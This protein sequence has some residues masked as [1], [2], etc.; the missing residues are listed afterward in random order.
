MV[1]GRRTHGATFEDM[2]YHTKKE[3]RSDTADL[4]INDDAT[5]TRKAH[6]LYYPRTTE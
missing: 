6:Y 4:M 3:D 5:T 2:N 1:I